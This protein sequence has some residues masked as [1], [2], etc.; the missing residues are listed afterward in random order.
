MNSWR[1][2]PSLW[3]DPNKFV[4]YKALVGNK[5]HNVLKSRFSSM[6]FQLLGNAALVDYIIRFNL[7][8]AVQPTALCAFC[9][10]WAD[11][12][13]SDEHKK[14]NKLSEARELGYVRRGK[15]IWI[16]K[17]AIVRGHWIAQWVDGSWSNRL[18]LSTGDQEIYDDYVSGRTHKSLRDV[19]ATPAKPRHAGA[20][21]F[22]ANGCSR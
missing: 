11:Y 7:C 2:S 16:L 20:G 18:S 21:S 4:S 5:K 6:K 8:G 22:I 19:L 12:T 10:K 9:N 1:N 13:N 15:Q 17:Q 3:M 14:A